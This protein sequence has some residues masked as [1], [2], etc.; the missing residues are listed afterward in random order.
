M[1]SSVKICS[2]VLMVF[3]LT[4]AQATHA[5]PIASRHVIW[6]NSSGSIVGEQILNCMAIGEHSGV[7]S[8]PYYREI[9]YG[10]APSV[11]MSGYNCHPI[12]QNGDPNNLVTVCDAV[13]QVT[14]PMIV[15]SSYRM[16]P[17]I[18]LEE[19]CDL[20]ASCGNEFSGYPQRIMSGPWRSGFGVGV[21][22]NP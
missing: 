22:T 12:A 20:I 18:S 11:Y 4:W 6:I 7:T 13:T 3:F 10:C 17:S 15:V 16:P 8:A 9:N 21:V 14:Q 5:K 19:S 2:F 1:H